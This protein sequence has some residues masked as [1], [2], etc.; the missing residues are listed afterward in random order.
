MLSLKLRSDKYELLDKVDNTIEAKDLHE[1]LHEL[2]FINT[3]L[4]GHKI[5]VDAVKQ[6]VASSNQQVITIAEIGCGGGDNLKHLD[7]Y[8]SKQGYKVS[9]IGIDLKQDCISYATKYNTSPNI[10]YYC[11]SYEKFVFKCKPNIIFSS[12]FCHHFSPAQIQLQLVWMHQNCLSAFFINDLQRH[13]LAFYSIKILTTLFSKSYLVKHD[14]PLSVLRAYTK[15]EWL[16]MCH[17]A[18]VATTVQWKW[19]FRFLIIYRQLNGN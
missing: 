11:S 16:T 19:A 4:G 10:T 8:F 2:D 5:N 1:N 17:T 13:R 9:L 3:Y 7:K 15:A 6:L 18:Q 14:A 12:L